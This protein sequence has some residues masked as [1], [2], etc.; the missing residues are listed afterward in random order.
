MKKCVYVAGKLNSDA[1]GYLKNVHVMIKA[2]DLIRR[3]G[4]AVYIPCLDLL[5][6]LVVGDYEYP[7]YADNNIVW[8]ARADV[9]YVLPDSE[10]SKGTQAEIKR[11]IELGIPVIYDIQSLACPIPHHLSEG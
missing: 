4:C 2:A 3:A 1:V 5:S 10:A 11:A 9:V 6:G 7:D 8:L